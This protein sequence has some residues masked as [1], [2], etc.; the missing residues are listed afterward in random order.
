MSACPEKV[1]EL[2]NASA[3]AVKGVR[4][5]V[6]ARDAAEGFRLEAL[7]GRAAELSSAGASAALS[8]AFR[9]VL[10][11]QQSGE[12]AAWISATESI[13]FPP[14]AARIGVD[15]EALAVIRANTLARAAGAA[16]LLMRSGGFG[17]VV[18]DL[19]AGNFLPGPSLMRLAGLAKKN[20]SALLFLTEKEERRPSLGSLISIRA[21]AKRAEKAGDRFRCELTILKDKCRGPGWANEGVY[22]GPDGLR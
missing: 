4:R 14:D 1:P 17:L 2:K 13:F 21:Q 15:L 6:P 5:G 9:L 11:A 22:H 8:F 7:F 3:L 19:G 18:M 12:P 20:G 10:E 16:D